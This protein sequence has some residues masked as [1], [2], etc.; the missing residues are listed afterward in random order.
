MHVLVSGSLSKVG[1]GCDST[2]SFV[3][4]TESVAVEWEPKYG[5]IARFYKAN[6]DDEHAQLHYIFPYINPE[7]TSWVQMAVYKENLPELFIC[8][9]FDG[10]FNVLKSYVS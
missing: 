9:N 6:A 4:Y 10:I 2:V 3:Y 5:P 7:K 1:N 8:G